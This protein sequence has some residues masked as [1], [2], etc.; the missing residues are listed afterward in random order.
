[1]KKLYLLICIFVLCHASPGLAQ[2]SFTNQNSR[3]VNQNFHSGVTV[4]IADWNF[5]G[6]DDIIHLDGGHNCYV[7]VQHTNHQYGRVNLGDFGGGSGWSWGMSIADLDH[8]GYLDI[9]AGGSGPSVKIIMTNNNGTGGTMVSLANT[10]F[11]VQNMTFADFNND[12][13]IDLFSC[14]DNAMS[15]IFLNDGAGHLAESTSV[16]NFDVTPTDDSGNYGSVWTDF[17]NDGDLDFYIAKC[18]QGVLD[19]TDGRRIDVLFVND[20]TNHFTESAAVYGVNNKWET[21]TGSFGDIDN[22]GDLDLLMT[23]HDHYSQIMENDGT[24]HYTDITAGTGFNIDDITPIESVFEDFDNDGYVDILV[25]GSSSRYFHNNGNHTFTKINDL[26]DANNLESFAI[27]DLNHDGFIDVYASYATIYTNPSSVNDV[28]WMNTRNANHFVTLQLIGTVSNKCAIGARAT[29]YNSL[30]TQIREV[31]AGESY[32]T[33]NTEMVHFGLGSTTAIDS[34][35]VR[36]PSGITQTIIN[37]SAD[38]FIR[39]I[40]NDCVSPTVKISYSNAAPVICTGTTQTFTA[41]SGLN[42]LWCDSITTASSLTITAGGEYNVTVSAPGNNCTAVSA[43][44]AIEQDPDQTPVL[45]VQGPTEFCNG[46]SVEIDATTGLLS[47][48]WSDGGNTNSINVSSTGDYYVTVQGYCNSFTSDTIS[49]LAHLVPDAI[50]SNVTLTSV[51]PATLNAVGTNL[52]WYD[53]ATATTPVGTGASFTTPVITGATSYW[54]ENSETYHGGSFNLGLTQ[55][56]GVNQYSGNTTSAQQIFDVTEPGVLRSVK[57][58]TDLAGVRR[59]ELRNNAGLLLNYLDVALVVDSQVVQLNFPLVPG[60]GY[61]LGTNDSVN[62]AI[63]TWGNISPRLKRNNSGVSYPYTV[64]DGM[65]IT[66]SSVGSQYYYY[67]YDWQYDRT[68]LTCVS[69]RVQ[70]DI[71]LVTGL[72]ELKDAGITVFPNPAH[73]EFTVRSVNGNEITALVIDATGRQMITQQLSGVENQL[74]TRNLHPGI[75]QLK[76]VADGKQYIRKLVIQ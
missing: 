30:G 6:L 9:A 22:D 65:S 60:T 19:T 16:I 73:E 27:G 49:V 47:Y 38:Q 11:F 15:H 71:D 76:L 52:S 3:L 46:S 18:R 37:P 34:I 21:W 43:T 20:G 23:N 54:V 55:P 44:V 64:P 48:S 32:G 14:D 42:Y 17:D 26:F 62:Q 75:Y 39:V 66:G 63:P 72:Q 41:T 53:N 8:N 74:S 35:V 40:E 59:F 31:R 56:T 68:G 25:S 33:A 57:V 7:E 24:G 69:N 70:V 10:G 13:W 12:G 61:T 58:Y 51:G 5:D 29:L 1:M 4:A 36:F 45:T 28:I 67:F 2:L 50:T